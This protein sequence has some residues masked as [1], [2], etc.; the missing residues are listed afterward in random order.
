MKLSIL[1]YQNRLEFMRDD[2]QENDTVSAPP[3]YI[4]I[5]EY[6]KTSSSSSELVPLSI[7]FAV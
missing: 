5:A 2:I 4:D 7:L 3:P 6:L 1:M